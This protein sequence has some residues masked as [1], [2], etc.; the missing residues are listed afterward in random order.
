MDKKTII[1]Y[2]QMKGMIFDAIHEN[3]VRTLGKGAVAYSIVTNHV[4]NARFTPKTEAV[5]PEPAEG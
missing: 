5:T 3:L 1:L 4:R 2:L